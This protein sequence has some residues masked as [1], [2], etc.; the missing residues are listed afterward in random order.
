MPN[1]IIQHN[2]HLHKSG[3]VNQNSNPSY[4]SQQQ[5][6]VNLDTQYPISAPTVRPNLPY[7]VPVPTAQ[8][9]GWNQQQSG[10][11]QQNQ[12]YPGSSYASYA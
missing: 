5:G 7:P 10:W 9:P 3:W 11:N 1:L 8:L 12:P 6:W 2:L 4:P